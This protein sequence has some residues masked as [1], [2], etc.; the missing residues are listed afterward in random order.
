[1]RRPCA[2]RA[3]RWKPTPRR[4]NEKRISDMTTRVRGAQALFSLILAVSL[5]GCGNDIAERTKAAASKEAREIFELLDRKG[6]KYLVTDIS[7]CATIDQKS[8]EKR[9]GYR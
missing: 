7:S 4:A 5:S 1:M 3:R 6:K 8:G 9:C 2:E